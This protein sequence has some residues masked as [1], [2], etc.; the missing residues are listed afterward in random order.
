MV[1]Y[2]IKLR[3]TK[4]TVH[5]FF[6]IDLDAKRFVDYKDDRVKIK[7]AMVKQQDKLR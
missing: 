1:Q 7:S 5:T 6:N 2:Y 3:K 4:L